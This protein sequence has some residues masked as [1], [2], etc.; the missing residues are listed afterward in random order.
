M[1]THSTIAIILGDHH[2]SR[3]KSIL[4]HACSAILDMA[5]DGDQIYLN[6]LNRND[7]FGSRSFSVGFVVVPRK[8]ADLGISHSVKKGWISLG[9]GTDDRFDSVDGGIFVEVEAASQRLS[10]QICYRLADHLGSEL[11]S[12]VIKP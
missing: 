5:F 8:D 6:R 2:Y 4:D 1:K 3:R 9:F 10:Q 12:Q 11:S 7:R